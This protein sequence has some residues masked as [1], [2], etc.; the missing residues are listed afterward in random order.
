VKH[1]G[2]F[3]K[4]QVVVL[5]YNKDR[6]KFLIVD[7]RRLGGSDNA[8][9]SEIVMSGY[10]QGRQNL[11]DALSRERHPSG[12]DWFRY[13][14]AHATELPAHVVALA[15]EEQSKMWL[16]TPSNY[17][18]KLKDAA[19]VPAQIADPAPHRPVLDAIPASNEA[20]M[21][22]DLALQQVAGLQ[23]TVAALTVQMAEL[24]SQMQASPKGGKK[25][26]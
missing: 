15:D 6:N 3:E 13:L 23:S 12:Q 10:A 18:P 24:L 21:K 1:I 8:K 19:L 16:G 17:D 9:L 5:G 22:A 7:P 14:I 11:S 2:M 25:K 4:S 26:G 20:S